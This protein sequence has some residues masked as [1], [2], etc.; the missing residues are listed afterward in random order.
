MRAC[1]RSLVGMLGV[2]SALAAEPRI[3]VDMGHAE[4][5]SC[6][7]STPDGSY[8]FTSEYDRLLVWERAS[9]R[10]IREHR[11][12]YAIHEITVIPEHQTAYVATRELLHCLSL[13]TFDEVFRADASDMASIVYEPEM[14]ALYGSNSATPRRS[15]RCAENALG[16][17]SRRPPCPLPTAMRNS[18]SS[19]R[20]PVSF[21]S[22]S[23]D[24]LSPTGRGS[25]ISTPT[26]STLR[27]P[28]PNCPAGS[29]PIHSTRRV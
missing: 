4:S 25:T 24:W 23:N 26:F 10:V 9:R 1:L 29:K 18:G 12:G 14:D 19:L 20:T 15:T 16:S 11:F 13:E 27:R 5:I 21:R 3:M 28:L 8:V 17:S 22:I 7:A 6:L 2:I